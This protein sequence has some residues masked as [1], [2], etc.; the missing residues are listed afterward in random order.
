M[1]EIPMLNWRRPRF[2]G[3]D[4]RADVP[5]TKDSRAGALIALTGAGRPRCCGRCRW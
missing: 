4:K 2:R 3:D 5:E 1:M